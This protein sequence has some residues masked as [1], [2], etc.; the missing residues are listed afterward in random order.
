[1]FSVTKL[2]TRPLTY[3]GE[4]GFCLRAGATWQDKLTLAVETIWFHLEHNR[5]GKV[6][7]TTVKIGDLRPRLRMRRYGGDIF[8]F[9]EVLGSAV[10][11]FPEKRLPGG[12]VI[13]DLGANI[14]LTALSLKARY[15]Q[16]RVVCVEPHPENA[17][18]LRHNLQCLG[19]SATILEAAVSATN[20]TIQLMLATEHY[21]ASVVRA[22]AEAVAVSA[23][24]MEEI[25]RCAGISTIDI[26]KMDI[27]GAELSILERRPAWL[28][29]VRVLLAELHGP[30]QDEMQA[31]LREMGFQVECEGSQ[32]KAWRQPV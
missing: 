7:E 12:L 14:G 1:M 30:R 16:A 19:D 27:E 17:A 9:H 23:L 26:L 28:Q 3:F 13:V 6:F 18:L 10:Y 11:S 8:I 2:L 31:W 32:L 20:G 24:T 21:N 29:K 5:L 25:M 22:G 15:P 4:L